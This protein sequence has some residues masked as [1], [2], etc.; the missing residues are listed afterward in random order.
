MERPESVTDP[1]LDVADQGLAPTSV[2]AGVRRLDRIASGLAALGSPIIVFNKSHSGSRLLA[3]LL[4]ELGVFMGS[5]LNGSQDALPF[6]DL[7]QYIVEKHVPN[8]QNLF[9]QGDPDL[10]GVVH[11]ALSAHLSEFRRPGLWGWKLCETVYIVP[12]LARLFPGAK[13]I[14]L[15]RDGRDVTFCDHVAPKAAFWRKVY[16]HTDQIER[17]IGLPLTNRSYRANSHVFN[18][19]H[20]VMSVSLGRSYGAM[21]GERYIEVRYEDLV[22]DLEGSAKILCDRVGI[23]YQPE[24]VHALARTVRRGSVSKWRR[25]TRWKVREALAV[26]EPTLS[27]FGYAS[28]RMEALPLR[29][30]WIRRLLWSPFRSLLRGNLHGA[31]LLASNLAL[32]AT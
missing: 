28:E 22:N 12:V 5:H 2:C 3:Q 29:R 24:R 31:V 23:P 16:F 11:A 32:L 4:A 26:L 1:H 17:W 19:R 9:T 7:V 10:E 15:V 14:H 20:W 21:L 6:V 13:F 18:A 8:Y 27:E 30:L 25:Q